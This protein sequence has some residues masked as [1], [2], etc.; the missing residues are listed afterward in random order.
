[1]G[2]VDLHLAIRTRAKAVIVDGSLLPIGSVRLDENSKFQPPKTRYVTL[3][4]RLGKAFQ[5]TAGGTTKLFRTPGLAIFQVFFPI[6]SG[7]TPALQLA[8]AIA[9]GFRAITVGNVMYETP[10]VATVGRT[11]DLW[12]VNVTCPFE[13]DLYA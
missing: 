10:E 6:D 2:A 3:T 5:A 1:M 12:Q 7:E 4:I 13:S 11:D 9:S 8:D